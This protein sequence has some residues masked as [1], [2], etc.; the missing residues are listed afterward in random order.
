LA[1]SCSASAPAGSRAVTASCRAAASP[2]PSPPP[3]PTRCARPRSL[4][5]DP[6]LLR[7]IADLVE[8]P[9]VVEGAFDEEYL[10]LPRE[11]LITTLRYHQKCFAVQSGSGELLPAFLAVANMEQDPA[12]HIRRGNEWVVG[13][14]LED[15]KFFWA[16]D[17]KRSLADRADDLGRVAFHAKAGSYADKARRVADLA[18]EV[19]AA[20]G[21]DDAVAAAAREAGALCKNDLVTGTVGEFPELQGIVGGLLLREEGAEDGVW[22]G[23]YEHYRP[24]GPDDPLPETDAGCAVAV[25]DKLETLSRL[26]EIGETP[27]SSRDPFGLRRAASG[28]F[29]IVVERG[30]A[31]SLETLGRLGSAERDDA[32]LT[33]LR[34][35]MENFFRERGYTTNEVRSVLLGGGG[36]AAATFNLPDVRARLDAVKGVRD[37][38]DF[39]HLV[40][41]TKR[42]ANIQ[43]KNGELLEQA[44]AAGDVEHD[45]PEPAVADIEK[46]IRE[47]GPAIDRKAGDGDYP[48][49]IDSLA[50]F[51]GPVDTFFDKALVIDP[52]QPETTAHRLR[53]LAR[54]RAVLT[55]HFDISELS[56]E[57]DRRTS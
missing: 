54:L 6:R 27:S 39:R 32:V 21:L 8:W 31:L 36:D 13:G 15:A 19:A 29:R 11:I 37:R 17:R 33:F 30:F 26:I 56:G 7:E 20:A 22:R 45:D 38:E 42:V 4:V 51:V 57:A 12:G 10:L 2:S 24:E 43:R 16:E 3:T 49:V 35:R 34:E 55:D 48:A 18:A 46:L 53:V 41:L 23:V 9:Q 14:R 52:E 28:V 5:E 1:S 47:A 25:A 50:G 44:L 40:E